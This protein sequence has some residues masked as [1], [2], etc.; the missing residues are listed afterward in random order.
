MK[1]GFTLIEL[2]AVIVILAVIALI[3][4]PIIINIINDASEQAE[5]ASVK[6]YLKAAELALT[7]KQLTTPIY[8][9]TCQV[10]SNGNMICDGEEV[11]VEMNNNK[12]IGG[13]IEI[14]DGRINN[15]F[16]L[17]TGTNS[18]YFDNNKNLVRSDQLD[19]SNVEYTDASC[20]TT[21]TQK[22]KTYTVTSSCPAVS[23][24]LVSAFG[25]PWTIDDATA[26]CN[27]EVALDIEI[28]QVLTN[29]MFEELLVENGA[30]TVSE[31]EP[32]NGIAITGY[33]CDD[34]DIVIPKTIDNKPVVEIA[35]SAFNVQLTNLYLTDVVLPNTLK[36]IDDWSFAYNYISS[37][38]IPSNVE[39][40]GRGAFCDNAIESLYISNS[41]KEIGNFAF[42]GNAMMEAYI[43][44]SVTRIGDYAF[45]ENELS[46]INIP[47]SVTYIGKDAFYDN[48][49]TSVVIPDS[50]TRI[51]D[52][53]FCGNLLT[54]LKIGNHVQ[55]IGDQA[56]N[57]NQLTSVTIPSSVI[58][59]GWGAFYAS[60][61]TSAN[62]QDPNNWHAN[63]YEWD[64]SV[65]VITES[66]SL[67]S[68][69]LS[70]PTIAATYLT[71]TYY[72][73]TWEKIAQ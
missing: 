64:D 21:T 11:P 51:G 5:V 8:D 32:I 7:R 44:N 66:D 27:G 62:F 24:S 53:A 35:W 14:R 6:S 4:T 68:S 20:F 49:I 34:T 33:T 23:Q 13:M 26:F 2:L 59:I 1:K 36:T 71:D 29:P 57:N 31:H 45:R 3:A 60:E 48:N 30:I 39:H 56:F 38:I 42:S 47:D 70:D 28:N 46:S 43:G 22:V 10:T 69:D 15:V 67:S 37:L 54:S 65:L 9:A 61:I 19:D 55:S 73:R 72:D 50:V 58:E 16:D 40:I 18:F 17:Y 12:V 52:Y 63:Y 25:I 41:V